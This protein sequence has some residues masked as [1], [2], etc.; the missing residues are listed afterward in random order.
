MTIRKRA[1][2]ERRRIKLKAC[3][4][5]R[6]S[7]GVMTRMKRTQLLRQSYGTRTHP[8]TLSYQPLQRILPSARTCLQRLRPSAF[9]LEVGETYIEAFPHLIDGLGSHSAN[10]PRKRQRERS[11]AEDSSEVRSST[12]ENHSLSIIDPTYLPKA[13]SYS[14]TPLM[15][16]ITNVGRKRAH[17]EPTFD[18][19]EVDL[20]D[21]SADPLTGGVTGETAADV[22]NAQGGETTNEDRDADGSPPKKKRKRGPRK[23]AGAKATIGSADGDEERGDADG[24]GAEN[25]SNEASDSKGKKRKAKMRTVRGPSPVAIP[26]CSNFTNTPSRT[27]R[28]LGKT[29]PQAN[30]RA[31]RQHH[32]FCL[33]RYRPRRTGLSKNCRWIHQ[34]ARKP[35]WFQC[36]WGCRDLLSLRFTEAPTL[37]LPR[38]GLR[39]L[40]S[41]SVCLLLCL[42]RQRSPRVQMPGEQGEGSIPKRWKL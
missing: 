25:K 9:R 2:F 19:N 41:S 24:E 40:E 31:E 21:P 42:Q 11:G 15:T 33:S 17:V 39:S 13:L 38:E 1:L 36:D 27:Q 8:G 4:S 23:K 12:I 14:R 20:E 29:T 32:L 30:S 3:G 7:P 35:K 37:S 5:S 18:Y 6:L 16:R 10:Q 34:T 28:S 26:P 22:A